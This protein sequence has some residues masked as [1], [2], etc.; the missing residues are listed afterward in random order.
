MKIDKS[1]FGW[2]FT[3]GLL[4]VLL[5]GSLYLGISGWYFKNDNSYTTDLKLGQTIQLDIQNNQA[6]SA[7]LNLDGAYLAEARLPQIISIKNVETDKSLYLRAKVFVYSGDNRNLDVDIVETINW[8]F[9]SDDGYYYFD[10]V[11]SANNK[12]ALCSHVIIGDNNEM[13]TNT[14]YILTVLVEALNDTEDIEQIWGYYPV[15]NI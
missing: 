8:K 1:N 9:N 12:I 11:L 6:N 3:C 4:F 14:K 5:I 7:S 15:E 10:D 2:I 13:N